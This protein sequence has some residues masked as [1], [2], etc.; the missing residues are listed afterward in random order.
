MIFSVHN[1]FK[2]TLTPV[3]LYPLESDGKTAIVHGKE[4]HA[5]SSLL[6]CVSLLET[7]LVTKFIEISGYVEHRERLYMTNSISATLQYSQLL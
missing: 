3:R 4:Y 1:P 6:V 5:V 2:L 7:L